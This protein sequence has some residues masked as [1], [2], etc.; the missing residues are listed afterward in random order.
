MRRLAAGALCA[1]GLLAHDLRAQGAPAFQ[2][3][4]RTELTGF[5]AADTPA[6]LIRRDK[7]SAAPRLSANVEMFAGRLYGFL[8]V[9]ADRGELPAEGSFELRLEQAF[10]RLNLTPALAVQA[11]RFI[12]PFGNY[13]QRSHTTAD[14]FVRP[15]I[16]YD[17]RTTISRVNV[18]RDLARFLEWKDEPQNFRRIGAPVVWAVPYQLGGA[19]FAT[20]GAFDA[21]V[22]ALTSAP[23]SEPDAWTR[24]DNFGP[25]FV[26]RATWQIIPELQ[27]GGSF[28]RGP[29]LDR[30][31]EPLMRAANFDPADFI[32]Q[33]I[34]FEFTATRA[35]LELRGELLFDRW[36]L[37]RVS[38]DPTDLSFYLEGKWKLLAG[39][40]AAARYGRI[41]FSTVQSEPW[42]YDIERW[43]LGVLYQPARRFEL[44]GEYMLNKG[45]K[46]DPN[47][48]L[49]ALQA[50]L[51]L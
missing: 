45:G 38:P 48:N 19:V 16:S 23:S 30:D 7:R 17:Y 18:P 32:Q 21:R 50:A 29:Y 22:A 13:P 3:S 4:G 9:R 26:A 25:S 43:Q 8:E 14:P 34:G 51:I 44:R 36:Q 12:T 49:F 42:D 6:S 46:A 41:D 40:A 37:A 20:A 2:F 47:D 27:I 15:P 1:C 5:V 28:D 35:L 31:I 10:A 33:I 24:L 39:L 11:G